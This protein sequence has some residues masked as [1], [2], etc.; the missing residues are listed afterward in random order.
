M[1]TISA[2]ARAVKWWFT[3]V[4]GDHDYDNYVDHLRRNHPDAEVPCEREYWRARH[5]QADANPGSRCC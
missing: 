2:A 3:S 4:L 1:K 5:A